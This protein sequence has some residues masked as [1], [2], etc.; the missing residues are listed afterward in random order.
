M[1]YRHLRDVGPTTL[2]GLVDACF[3][4]TFGTDDPLYDRLVKRSVRRVLKSVDFMRTQGVV[5]VLQPTVPSSF[6]LVIM[7]QDSAN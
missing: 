5:I 6:A 1:V 3:P 2:L 4:T 7:S